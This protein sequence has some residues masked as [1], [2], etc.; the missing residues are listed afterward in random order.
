[1]H[2]G[3]SYSGKVLFPGEKTLKSR[4]R[5]DAFV[6]TYTEVPEGLSGRKSKVSGLNGWRIAS[7]TILLVVLALIISAFIVFKRHVAKCKKR[8]TKDLEVSLDSSPDQLGTRVLRVVK[9]METGE[10]G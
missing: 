8:S 4:G 1:M 7:T 3:G 9:N 10:V 6:A 2:I 5:N